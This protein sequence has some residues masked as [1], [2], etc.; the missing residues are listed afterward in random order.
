VGDTIEV[1]AKLTDLRREAS[2]QAAA[3]ANEQ[4]LPAHV[5]RKQ[6]AAILL[7]QFKRT[8]AQTLETTEVR[9]KR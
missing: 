3:F 1:L 9:A 5:T 2:G 7:D 6:A 8:V 4:W